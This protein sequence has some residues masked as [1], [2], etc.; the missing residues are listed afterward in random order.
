MQLE[1]HLTTLRAAEK[2]ERPGCSGVLNFA[3]VECGVRAWS[4]ERVYVANKADARKVAS[5][6]GATP[7]NF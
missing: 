6:R 4:A 1:S 3:V 7:W 5:E 2:R